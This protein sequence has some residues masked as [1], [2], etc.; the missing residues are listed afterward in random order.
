MFRGEQSRLI[1]DGVGLIGKLRKLRDRRD[2]LSYYL[3]RLVLTI[4]I[5]DFQNGKTSRLPPSSPRVPDDFLC[6]R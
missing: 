3:K 5:G 1:S 4:V 2:V 6:F